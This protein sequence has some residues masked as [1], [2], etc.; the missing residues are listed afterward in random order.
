MW[1]LWTEV[2]HQRY[3]NLVLNCSLE[4]CM[5]CTCTCIGGVNV[6]LVNRS[7]GPVEGECVGQFSKL[8]HVLYKYER[9]VLLEIYIYCIL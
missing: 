7:R 8:L 4:T 2:K 1:S 3:W 9:G 5:C 6:K